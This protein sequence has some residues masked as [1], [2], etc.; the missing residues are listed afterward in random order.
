[1]SLYLLLQVLA[2]VACSIVV[3]GLLDCSRVYRAWAASAGLGLNTLYQ[4]MWTLPQWNSLV[5]KHMA[6]NETSVWH[7]AVL[8]LAFGAIY[9][10]HRCVASC[11]VVTC[12]TMLNTLGVQSLSSHCLKTTVTDLKTTVTDCFTGSQDAVILVILF[13]SVSHCTACPQLWCNLAHQCQPPANMYPCMPAV[14]S[15]PFP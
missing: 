2:A 9:H 13:Y 14:S 15:V 6:R 11:I 10:I 12:C 4:M 5:T 8:L 3:G 1:M 7:A